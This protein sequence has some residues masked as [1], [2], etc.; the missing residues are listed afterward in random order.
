MKRKRMATVGEMHRAMESRYVLGPPATG[1]RV[2]S[3]DPV[4]F[5]RTVTI[6]G[7]RAVVYLPHELR[8]EIDH[9]AARLDRS[10]SWLIRR[11]WL[12]ARDRLRAMPAPMV[13]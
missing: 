9:E 6:R 8:A 1:L 2:E 4:I 10:T 3:L 13:R 7:K 5:A 12:L 11:A